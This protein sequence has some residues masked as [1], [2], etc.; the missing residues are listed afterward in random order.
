MRIFITPG[1]APHHVAIHP[2]DFVDFEKVLEGE[3][4]FTPNPYFPLVAGTT[5]I[6]RGFDEDGEVA[7][8]IRVEVLEETKEVLGIQCIVVRDRVWEFD[9]EGSK[10]LIEDARDWYARDLNGNV[11]CFGEICKN[12][13]EGELVD[14]E[15][16]WKAGK[17]DAK[18]GV[19][20]F[21]DPLEGDYYRQE[22]FLGEAE[23]QVLNRGVESVAV[24]YG[25]EYSDDVLKTKDFS[26]MEPGVY[27]HK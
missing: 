25:G 15:G 11:W 26:P 17:D 12:F 21:A 7:E 19:L 1:Q 5:W 24:P 16:S 6:Y 10:V 2:D 8:R 13:E 20:M 22:F 9:D 3:E 23:A 4:I 14:L 18:P 27:E